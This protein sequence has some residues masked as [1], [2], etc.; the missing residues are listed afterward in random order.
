MVGEKSLPKGK[1]FVI[2]LAGGIASGKSTVADLLDELGARTIDSDALTTEELADPQVV[3]TFRDWWG[4]R[5]CAPD[6]TINRKVMGD[7]IFCDPA[8]R[9]RMEAFLY[10][11]LERRRKAMMKQFESDPA[12]RAIVI[13]APLLFEV[14]LDRECDVVVF[15]DCPRTERLARLRAK[16]D[17]DEAEL[18]RRENLQ[19]PLDIKAQAADY[20]VVNNSTI[21]ALRDKVRPLF[22]RLISSG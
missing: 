15:V 17:W 5:V 6:G 14:G 19:K 4:Q 21:D 11:R 8:Q 22:D 9:A 20:T 3:A 7:I 12:V 10:P 1:K 18:D 2:G 13:N 16:R